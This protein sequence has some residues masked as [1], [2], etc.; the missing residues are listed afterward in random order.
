MF[1]ITERSIWLC[2]T[3][4]IKQKIIKY[5]TPREF[6]N[7]IYNL[8]KVLWLSILIIINIIN[9]KVGL[10]REIIMLKLKLALRINIDL[11]ISIQLC[12]Q[13]LYISKNSGSS[14]NL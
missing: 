4:E 13:F 5:W 1:K 12:C 6:T 14:C 11:K 7:G 8:L 2:I 10:D 9:W 3:A